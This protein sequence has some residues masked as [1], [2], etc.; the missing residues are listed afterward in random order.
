VHL[1]LAANAAEWRRSGFHAK[2]QRRK[3]KDAKG[4]KRRREG[5]EAQRVPDL[6]LFF[7]CFELAFKQFLIFIRDDHN[8]RPFASFLLSSLL[9]LQY[10]RDFAMNPFPFAPL[11]ED[12]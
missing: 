11:R 12:F 2:A 6:R 3:A 8:R 5:A 1:F 7:P 9:L 10:A 4:F